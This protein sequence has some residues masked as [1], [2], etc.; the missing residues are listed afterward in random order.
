[1]LRRKMTPG[2]YSTGVISLHYRGSKPAI[3]STKVNPAIF[4]PIAD[5]GTRAEN[6]VKPP[7]QQMQKIWRV[8]Y[9]AK[10]Q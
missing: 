10:P 5:S 9:W 1:M 2:H 4:F 7:S 8:N 3:F 6:A